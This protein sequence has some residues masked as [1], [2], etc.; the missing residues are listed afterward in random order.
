MLRSRAFVFL[1]LLFE[2]I[3]CSSTSK[4]PCTEGGQ[5]AHDPLYGAPAFRGTKTCYQKP[6]GSGGW[7]NDGK[8]LEKY[9]SEKIAVTGEFKMGKKTG[10]WIEYDEKGKKISDRY[11]DEGK[12]IPP[13]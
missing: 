9:P 13:P 2:C 5:P 10:R 1:I 11:F 6:D 7:V 4:R 12:E 8:Y 3:G